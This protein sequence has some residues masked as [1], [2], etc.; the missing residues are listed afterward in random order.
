MGGVGVTVGVAIGVNDGG[1]IEEATGTTG[2]PV[3]CIGAAEA[4]REVR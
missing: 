3:R 1:I 4:H 2:T